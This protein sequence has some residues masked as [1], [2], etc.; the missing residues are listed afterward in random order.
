M[1]NFVSL[2]MLWLVLS[3]CSSGDLSI[4]FDIIPEDD[5]D[6]IVIDTFS[7]KTEMFTTSGNLTS[8]ASELLTGNKIYDARHQFQ[9]S[10][11]FTLSQPLLSY[12]YLTSGDELMIDSVFLVLLISSYEGDSLSFQ[13]FFLHQLKDELLSTES[14]QSDEN[15]AV[16]SLISEASVRLKNTSD[17]ALIFPISKDFYDPLLAVYSENG[18]NLTL[19]MSR[20]IKG[21]RV[22][23]DMAATSLIHLSAATSVMRVFGHLANSQ[24]TVLVDYPVETGTR[25]FNAFSFLRDGE[26]LDFSD[27]STETTIV[28]NGLPILT[29]VSFPTLM[30]LEDYYPGYKILK[31]TLVFY[32]TRKNAGSFSGAPVSLTLYT[33]N[34]LNKPEEPVSL[35]TGSTSTALYQND[36]SEIIYKGFY[37]FELTNYMQSLLNYESKNDGIT[38][39]TESTLTNFNST[40]GVL[41]GNENSSNYACRLELYLTKM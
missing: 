23:G 41:L 3:S 30:K 16:G 8:G 1:N 36:F 18:E 15:P 33:L 35:V 25:L 13:K 28:Q 29:K 12:N 4:G 5:A 19:R 27:Q 7:V 6:V 10:A 22:R 37:S 21:L 14:Y 11:Y 40:E 17:T 34:K 38:M 9:A 20:I 24:T 2:A 32:S 31:A 39:V 26:A